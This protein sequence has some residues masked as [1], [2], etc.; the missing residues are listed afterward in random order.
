MPEFIEPDDTRYDERSR[1]L[2][3][4]GRTAIAQEDP[5][6]LRDYFSTDFQFHGPGAELDFEGLSSF[7]GQMRAAFSG[8]YCERYDIVAAGSLIGC[9]TEMGGIFNAPFEPTPFGT[10]QPHSER[11]TLTLINMF[12]YDAEGK[13]AEEWVQYDNMEWMHQLGMDLVPTP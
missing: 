1:A 7:F 12:R 11:V 2:V 8:Y 9:R 13:L 6:V 4:V 3:T 5:A 10:V